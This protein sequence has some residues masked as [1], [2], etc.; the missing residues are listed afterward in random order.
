[1]KENSSYR[2]MIFSIKSNENLTELRKTSSFEIKEKKQIIRQNLRI[3]RDRKAARSLF[4]LV[5]VFLIFLFPYVI[6]A[7]A[8][9]AGFKISSNLFE[10]SFWLL[11]INSTFNPFLYP[12]IQIKYRKAYQQLFQS[13]FKSSN[14]FH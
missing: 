3:I 6:C 11:W 8:T 9:T 2:S 14:S 7:I 10:I 1:M 13:C 5:L 4:I 12:F